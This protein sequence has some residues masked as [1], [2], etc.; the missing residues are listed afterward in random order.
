MGDAELHSGSELFR[1]LAELG[2]IPF[3]RKGPVLTV[4]AEEVHLA[5]F[6][7]DPLELFA[8]GLDRH[9]GRS[10][11]FALMHFFLQRSGQRF[12]LTSARG[13]TER[14]GSR[15][16]DAERCHHAENSTVHGDS[17][18]GC[19]FQAITIVELDDRSEG[20]NFPRWRQ[21]PAIV[22]WARDGGIKKSR[23]GT[24]A[25]ANHTLLTIRHPANVLA[26]AVNW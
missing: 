17:P 2:Q 22:S 3:V 20:H 14:G 6:T 1:Q 24:R 26:S 19:R 16:S 11:R 12:D 21:Q 8:G 15:R 23:T 25:D 5:A 10:D 4:H 18:P 7:D 13:L 9:S